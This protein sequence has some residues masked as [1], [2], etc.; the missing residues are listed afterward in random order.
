[1][2]F[3]SV[4]RKVAWLWCLSFMSI[5]AIAHLFR[6]SFGIGKW[7]KS[8]WWRY[9]YFTLITTKQKVIQGTTLLVINISNNF[10]PNGCTYK[11]SFVGNWDNSI[12]SFPSFC[13]NS[14]S[15][16]DTNLLLYFSTWSD[17]S[18]LSTEFLFFPHAVC[19]ED[20][21]KHIPHSA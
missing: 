9:E 6:V 8:S 19:N 15:V 14:W 5:F 4:K 11:I 1:M 17:F 20:F 18:Q 2:V 10:F 16:Y 13:I 12:F 21:N 3:N 7:C